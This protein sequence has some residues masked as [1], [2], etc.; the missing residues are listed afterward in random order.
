MIP[1]RMPWDAPDAAVYYDPSPIYLRSLI[2]RAGIS[3][4]MA[5][6]MIGIGDRAMR[7]YLSVRKANYPV[8]VALE[9]LAI[10]LH[11]QLRTINLL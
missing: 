7:Y 8:Q 11:D 5:A 9:D 6:K 2:K 10:S 3:Q 1:R 4:Q